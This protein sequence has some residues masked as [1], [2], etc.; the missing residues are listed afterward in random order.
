MNTRSFS[1]TGML[2]LLLLQMNVKAQII[3]TGSSTD[4]NKI[5]NPKL[6]FNYLTVENGLSQSSILSIAQDSMGF[7][8]FGTKDGLNKF[9]TQTFEVYRHNRLDS[10][11]LS[12]SQNI[13]A[14]L[15][16]RKGRL[17]VA[18]QK[19]LNVYVPESNSFKSYL[20]DPNNKNSLSNSVIRSL[21]QD[22]QGYIWIGTENGLNKM[23]GPDK[24]QRFYEGRDKRNSLA[25]SLI[26]AIHQDHTNAMW[27]GTIAGLSKMTLLNGKYVFQSY[28]HEK[29]NPASLIDD[30][31]TTVYEDAHN[32]LW[33]GTHNY[34][35][36][37]LDRSTG[38]FKH[39]DV[40]KGDNDGISSN[41]IRKM[42]M[43]NEGRLWISTLNGINIFNYETGKFSTYTH[44]PG[45]PSSLNQN[46]IYDILQDAAGSMW[47]GT[48]YGGVNV[49]HA[50][51]TPFRKFKANTQKN[52][53]SSNVISAI[54]EDSKNNL[55]IGTE[56]EGLNYYDRAKDKFINFKSDLY[57]NNSLSSN[58]VKAISIDQKG[59]VWL[60]TYEGG[61]DRYESKTGRFKRYRPSDGKNTINSS[62]IV[63][64]M[65]DRHGK[66]WIGTRAQG[67]ICY[68][69]ITDVFT[70]FSDPVYK[71][72]LTRHRAFFE[73][74]RGNIW[75]STNSGTFV[76]PANGQPLIRLRSKNDDF[77]FD[78][79]NFIR[80]DAA[81]QIWLGSYA[82][83]LIRYDPV[84]MTT[85]F[86]TTEDGL[87][88]N[89]VLG[90]LEDNAGK[91]WISTS[92]G[93]A[94]FDGK[95]FINYTVDDGLTGNV[96]N[97]NSFFKDSRGEMFFG[98]YNGLISFFPEQ[99]KTNSQVP[100]AV[101]TQLR[102]FNKPVSIGDATKLLSR[103]INLTKEITFSYH[104]NI[105]SIDFA[106]LNYIKPEK[107]RYAYK[108][109]GFEKQWNYVNSPSAAFTNLPAGTYTLLIKGANNDGV[110]TTD[111]ERMTIYV[112]PPFWKTWW[113]YLL[114]FICLSALVF[115]ILRF[116]W[117]R[118]LL[119]R[120]HEIFQ[121]KLDFFTNVSHEIRTPLTLIVGPL[122]QLV[123][124]TQ[125]SPVLNRKLLT[126]KRN[127]GRLTR[128]VS[129][130]MDFR[131]AE[132]GHLKL[133]IEP[134]N[135]VGFAK[136]IFLSFQ[137]MAIRNKIDYTFD[138][139]EEDI[140]AYF[141][142][143]QLEKVFYNLLSNAFKFTAEQ[144]IIRLQINKINPGEVMIT[145]SDN[146]KGIPEESRGK[147]FSNFYQVREHRSGNTGTG[148]GLA[149]A[150]KISKL[151]HGSLTLLENDEIS[152]SDVHTSF[153][154]KLKLGKQHFDT[155]DLSGEYIN[156]EDPVYYQRAEAD[157][158][159]TYEDADDPNLEITVLIVEDNH[160]VRDFITQSLKR[161]YSIIEAENGRQGIEMAMEHIPDLIVSDVMMPVTDGLELCRELKTDIRTS[162]IPI[163]L[164]T[165][166]S[167]NIHEVNGLKTGAE[168][169]IT[170]PFSINSL[171]LNIYNLLTLQAN[172]RRK[173]SQQLTLQPSN[174]LIESTDE[175]FLN[176]I[177]T[178]IEANLSE[179]DF[180]VN[181]LAS[182]VG[183]STPI[184]YKK[185]KALT[186]LTV[187]NFIK[188]IRLKRAAQLLLQNNYTVYEV[189]YMVGFSDS[190]YFSKE[191]AKQFGQT[192]SSFIPA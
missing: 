86:Y 28:Y 154:L 98:G 20:H 136:E 15:T 138:S 73:D 38:R 90:M 10:T 153:C 169:Y 54:A 45:D 155:S 42:K 178:I 16:D 112:N 123:K 142:S 59:N 89:N 127:A 133:N 124:E 119:R 48:Y 186:G 64:L 104:Q 50:N 114:Y 172:M 49:Y 189:A 35:L 117:I 99:V 148:I 2:L 3:K 147:I 185:I 156:T 110:W 75:I 23:V 22:R 150:E 70:L 57:N 167:G 105:F 118:A 177:M 53:I 43:D 14:L 67:I 82:S 84:K 111:S 19:G 129:E 36:D 125:E 71:D 61:L 32:N 74:S 132:S 109:E 139:S 190:K 30:D 120:E 47:L 188:S 33:I 94:K 175:D 1:F 182:E 85:K 80:E 115:L 68:D 121:M 44:N 173:F 69:D 131:K 88:A 40:R 39:F 92:N 184:L 78:D 63:N 93:L 31:V 165:A 102:L 83:G 9:D 192:P 17:W 79:I 137:H 170:K 166:R 5:R 62:R 97:T 140:E 181:T 107:N 7:M 76:R 72:E 179:E 151:H 168:A 149:L 122:E 180:N 141:D 163:I 174:V 158:V 116:L 145:V 164:L 191:F 26:K 146:G 134:A 157:P 52:G 65:H 113:A 60:G 37:L 176:K 91:L 66:L 171:Q 135:I 51:S 12:S 81:H 55:W 77:G 162:H 144:G 29:D 4:V 106:I 159:L 58:L 152:E 34:G 161:F 24:F 21:Y 87:P 101:F 160:E 183:M 130:L 126:V 13:N 46:S 100:K 56:A 143:L 11:S 103:N 95:A 41:F 108:L 128:L 6:N 18:T 8:W 96:F 25:S 187:N 27:I